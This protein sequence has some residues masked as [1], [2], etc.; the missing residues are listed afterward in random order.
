MDSSRHREQLAS[1]Q[2]GSCDLS[3]SH[4]DIPFTYVHVVSETSRTG[5]SLIVDAR[6]ADE[7][8]HEAGVT[9]SAFAA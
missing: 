6:L 8:S 7:V 1:Q 3:S 5:A 2:S 9:M 4:R